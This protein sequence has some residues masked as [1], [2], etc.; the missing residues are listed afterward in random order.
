[1][2]KDRPITEED[3][4]L[5]E[6][7]LARSYGRLKQSVSQATS[8]TFGSLGET[9]GET[10][11]KHP[12]AT[13]GVAV[14]AGVILYGLF[15]LLNRDGSSGDTG[16][17]KHSSRTDMRGEILSQIL[18]VVMPYLAAYLKRYLGRSGKA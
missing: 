3:I 5:T 2:K 8:D 17:G 18:P 1:V 11:R 12:Y 6:L 13:A 15:R 10:V 4:L 16:R 9:V 14:G 7:L